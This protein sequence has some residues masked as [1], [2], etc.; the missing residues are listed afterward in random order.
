MAWGMTP[1]QYGELDYA[2]QEF[3]EAHWI[4]KL[5]MMNNR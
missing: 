3:I 4:T 5:K 1:M 2:E